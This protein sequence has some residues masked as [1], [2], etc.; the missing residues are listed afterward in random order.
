MSNNDDD[1]DFLRCLP[2]FGGVHT[3]CFSEFCEQVFLIFR[4][5]H[6]NT[7]HFLNFRSALS[8]NVQLGQ[9]LSGLIICRKPFVQEQSVS[10]HLK[11][12]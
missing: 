5:V 6:S 11:K 8:R 4:A 7:L 1:N 10:W 9:T 2:G 3:L 12:I